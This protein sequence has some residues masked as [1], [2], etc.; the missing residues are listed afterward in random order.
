MTANDIVLL[1]ALV[2]K[3]KDR[4][5][6]TLSDD[7]LFELFCLEQGLKR[8]A[9]TYEDLRTGWVDGGRDGGIDGFFTLVDDNL[10]TIDEIP[11]AHK[12]HPTIEIVVCT[13]KHR[14]SFQ[15]APLDQLH[16]SLAELLDLSKDDSA[17][18]YPYNDSVLEAR[19]IFRQALLDNAGKRF[20]FRAQ[21]LYMCRGDARA[22]GDDLRARAT[23]LEKLIQRQI[24]ETISCSV[25]FV[26][27]SELLDLAR[28]Q[29]DYSIKLPFIESVLSRGKT[30]YAILCRLYDYY[31]F[32]SAEDGS[33]RRHLFESN[34]RDYLGGKTAVNKDIAATLSGR[35]T[36]GDT[37]DFWWLNNGVTFLAS[38]ASTVGK[39]MHLENVQ[40][41]NGLQTTETIY[42]WFS[43][44]KQQDNGS[45]LKTDDR[46]ILVKIIVTEDRAV[47]D[48]I[49]KASNYQTPVDAAFL[50]A[51]DKIQ[52]DIEAYLEGRDW[53][54]ERRNGFWQNHGKSA[55]RIVSPRQLA[56]YVRAIALCDPLGSL[57]SKSNI[58]RSDQVYNTVFNSSWKLDV[59]LACLLIARNI[60]RLGKTGQ[61]P[62]AEFNRGHLH[63]TLPFAA[64][65]YVALVLG[66]QKWGPEEVIQVAN[67]FEDGVAGEAL[68]RVSEQLLRYI[69]GKNAANKAKRI[70]KKRRFFE[71]LIAAAGLNAPQLDPTL[72]DDHDDTDE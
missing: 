46:A 12:H 53:Y 25:T 7:E 19:E 30:N 64:Y 10:A 54:Y 70:I 27:A 24:R 21:I 1:D 16:A 38:Y 55:D 66:R 26:G 50:R 40:I 4:L 14:S 44:L 41:V 2:A 5:G 37:V 65:L 68:G 15:Q 35:G 20:Q 6:T 28:R 71:E 8:Y 69:A 3:S 17:L 23:T 13:V 67:S 32:V 31:R 18:E 33:L 63:L 48:R 45:S 72:A 22:V 62:A 42:N 58:F 34:I 61:V 51:T 57:S 36:D 11:D 49:I 59:Y 39:E 9:L 43:Q 56:K 47:L 29:P 60:E 52:R